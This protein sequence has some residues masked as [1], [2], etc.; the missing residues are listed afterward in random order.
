MSAVRGM[1]GNT[2]SLVLASYER[3]S[4]RA[5]NTPIVYTVHCENVPGEH[6]RHVVTPYSICANVITQNHI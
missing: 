4:V 1:R 3:S 2:R 5:T 6:K